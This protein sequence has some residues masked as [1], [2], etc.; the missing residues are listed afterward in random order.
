[1]YLIKVYSLQ[2]KTPLVQWGAC[3][4]SPVPGDKGVS[5]PTRP[6][7]WTLI[8]LSTLKERVLDGFEP[9][10]FSSL[11]SKTGG[12][13]MPPEKH[14]VFARLWEPRDHPSLSWKVHLISKQWPF[15]MWLPW[16]S[17]TLFIFLKVAREVW[18]SPVPTP[19]DKASE[20]KSW[21]SFLSLDPNSDS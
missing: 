18:V 21:W 8:I 4:A 10:S 12:F 13:N 6:L 5:G 1:M 14:R 9:G 7:S 17:P 15:P 16:C 20:A 2:A 3:E 11:P 19:S